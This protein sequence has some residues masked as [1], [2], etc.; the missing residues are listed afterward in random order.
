MMKRLIVL[1]IWVNVFYAMSF[2]ADE[3]T[4]ED[5]KGELSTL[6]SSREVDCARLE[7]LYKLYALA[8]DDPLGQSPRGLTSYINGHREE[9]VMK[10]NLALT[11]VG[12]VTKENRLLL[13]VIAAYGTPRQAELLLKQDSGFIEQENNFGALP[14]DEAALRDNA[15]MVEYLVLRGSGKSRYYFEEVGAIVHTT[16]SREHTRLVDRNELHRAFLAIRAQRGD[17]V[18][19]CGRHAIKADETGK[20]QGCSKEIPG[21]ADEETTM[22][23]WRAQ[24]IHA[25]MK[26]PELYRQKVNDYE[27]RI[28]ALINGEEYKPMMDGRRSTNRQN[29]GTEKRRLQG[30]TSTSW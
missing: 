26:D 14:V 16:M 9:C 20:S 15:E 29:I 18:P 7:T 6:C 2:D 24:R 8:S 21:T 23:K 22:R 11:K 17:D 19:G 5:F 13:H 28:Q 1:G 25:M 3:L 10:L 4:L 27:S 30:K 12:K